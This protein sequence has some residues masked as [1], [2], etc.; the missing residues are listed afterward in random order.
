M[1]KILLSAFVSM[2]A[3]QAQASTQELISGVKNNNLPEVLK[4]LAEGEDVNGVNEQGNTALHYAVALDNADMTQALLSYGADLNLANSKGWTPLKIAEKKDLANVTPV[5]VKYLGLQGTAK[6]TTSEVVEK[7]A[8]VKNVGDT[9]SSVKEKAADAKEIVEESVVEVVS[10]VENSPKVVETEV[11]KSVVEAVSEDNTA[12]SDT[13]RRDEMIVIMERAADVI[14]QAKTAQNKAEEE[15]KQLADELKK[16]KEEKADLEAKLSTVSKDK[17]EKKPD[18]KHKKFE[19]PKFRKDVKKTPAKKAAPKPVKP[20]LKKKPVYK[21]PA[22]EVK[23]VILKPSA[24]VN[25]IYAGDEEIIYCLDYFG[26][27]ENEGMKRAA[28]YFAA[29]ASVSEPRYKEI[30]DMVYSYYSGASEEQL[31]VRDKQCSEV[32]TPKDREKQNQIIRSM[33][34]A[35]GY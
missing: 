7:I 1:K 19:K 3:M 21:A 18:M 11:V 5:L 8:E 28:G 4:M 34:K 10:V 32:I 33:N 31:K 27:G 22:P 14:N 6:E 29:S 30:V 20:S 26:N 12:K 9:V 16:V 35:V 25:G 24:M 13:P 15:A 23:K 17:V 2:L